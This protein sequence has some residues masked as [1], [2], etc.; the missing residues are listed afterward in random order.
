MKLF[1]SP[2]R[3]RGSRSKNKGY[4][5]ES[6][7][8]TKKLTRRKGGWGVEI[9]ADARIDSFYGFLVARLEET[10]KAQIVIVPR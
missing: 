7:S 8:Q 1:Y 6:L 3:V 10:E 2:L 5:G 9:K 4:R